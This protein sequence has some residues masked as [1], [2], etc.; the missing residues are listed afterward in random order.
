[1]SIADASISPGP[2]PVDRAFQLGYTLA[3]RL[4]RRYWRWRHPTTHGA[5]V[6]IWNSGEVLLIRNSYIPYYSAPGGYVRPFETALQ[7]AVRELA[8]EVGTRVQSNQL[9][10]ALE[11]T[12]EWEYKT[13]HVIVFN[14]ELPARPRIQIDHR[15]VVDA[16]WFKPA[17]ALR[18]NV[19]PPL[20]TVIAR[21]LQ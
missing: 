2:S 9:Q 14:L 5:L 10:Q 20:K 19:F 7:A 17:E 1:M 4:M 21:K 12:H 11:V 3:Y 16:R 6:A 8:E 13:D 18:L 15:E